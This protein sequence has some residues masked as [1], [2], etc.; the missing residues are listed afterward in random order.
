MR[1]ALFL[2]RDGVIN[3]DHGYVWQPERFEVL[4]GVFGALRAAQ[5]LGY[6]LIVITNQ[7]G[8]ARGYFN[9]EDYAR[10]EAH[11]R[12]I[13]ASEGV[14][15]DGIYHCPHYSLDADGAPLCACRKP[16]PGMI[17]RAAA[18]YAIDLAQS[19]LVGDKASDLAAA[20]AAGVGRAYRVG[21]AADG[22]SLADVVGLLETS[23][24]LP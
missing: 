1:R 9:E 23:P 3:V 12:S 19:I 21:E 6:A 20:S 7:S 11:M 2:D 15:F 13:F 4:P 22:R 18:D 16:Q 10:L 5:T 8:I 17:L 24:P 14:A